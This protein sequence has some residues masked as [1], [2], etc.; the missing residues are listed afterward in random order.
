MA[1]FADEVCYIKRQTPETLAETTRR[2]AL[3]STRSGVLKLEALNPTKTP[4]PW[5]SE[6]VSGVWGSCFGFKAQGLAGY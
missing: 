2:C 6:G 4:N 5:S 1:L 3:D